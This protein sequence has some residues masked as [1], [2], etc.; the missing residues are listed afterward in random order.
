[1][2]LPGPGPGPASGL[3]RVVLVHK[4]LYVGELLMQILE[5]GARLLVYNVL[6]VLLVFLNNPSFNI[7]K[8]NVVI[9]NSQDRSVMWENS[10][11]LSTRNVFT[12]N[13]PLPREAPLSL[14]SK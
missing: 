14:F 1:M 10:R 9:I 2:W 4:L 3:P 8:E 7:L 11:N 5:T 6:F 13:S 12:L